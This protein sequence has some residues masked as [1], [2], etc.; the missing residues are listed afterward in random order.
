MSAPWCQVCHSNECCNEL[1]TWNKDLCQIQL[2]IIFCRHVLNKM[3]QGES[4]IEFCVQVQSRQQGLIMIILMNILPK[5]T[6]GC[7]WMH[8]MHRKSV[9]SMVL[10]SRPPDPMLAQSHNPVGWFDPPVSQF[11]ESITEVDRNF[12]FKTVGIS[13]VYNWLISLSESKT[14]GI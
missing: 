7:G 11:Y 1:P 3:F 13:V 8:Q 9:P 4:S 12:C 14:T 5:L 10:Q 6:Q 2:I